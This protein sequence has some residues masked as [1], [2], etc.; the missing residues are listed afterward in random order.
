[1]SWSVSAVGKASLVAAKIEEEFSKSH[2]T[3]PE[4]SLRQ[5]ARAAIASALAAST[6]P[7]N[8]VKVIASGH[9]SEKYSPK[10]ERTGQFSNTLSISVEPICGFVE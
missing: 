2:C 5:S 8:L 9:Q 7:D 1:M 10:G 6:N 4:E 3:E